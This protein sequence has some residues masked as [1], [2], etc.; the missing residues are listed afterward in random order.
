MNGTLSE[1][2][3]V[4]MEGFKVVSA[5]LFAHPARYSYPAMTLWH[6]S[7]SCNK[8]AV[9]ALNNCERIRIEVNAA[10]KCILIVPVTAKDK[11]GIRWSKNIKDPVA[12]K[13]ECV[14]FTSMLYEQWHWDVNTCYRTNGRL[15]TSDQKVMLLFNF[16]EPEHWIVGEKGQAENGK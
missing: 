15:V 14:R 6:T 4:N 7:L 3:E 8:A 12:K 11:D 5:E 2:Q 16:T 13:I 1:L 10:K 9:I